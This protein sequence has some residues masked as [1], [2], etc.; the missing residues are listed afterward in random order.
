MSAM[1]AKRARDGNVKKEA[2]G[3]QVQTDEVQAAV[4]QTAPPQDDPLALG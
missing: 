3:D 2:P 4:I 1:P